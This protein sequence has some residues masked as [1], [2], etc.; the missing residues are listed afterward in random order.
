[1]IHIRVNVDQLVILE[2]QVHEPEKFKPAAEF[3]QIH[4]VIIP[5]AVAAYFLCQAS[6]ESD[7]VNPFP[8]SGVGWHC[9]VTT[10]SCEPGRDHEQ[11]NAEKRQEEK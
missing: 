11:S 9:R 8:G 1:M 3:C 4:K 2:N 7:L 10:L 6:V 5:D